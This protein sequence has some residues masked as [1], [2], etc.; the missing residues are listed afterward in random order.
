MGLVRKK[1]RINTYSLYGK[2]KKQVS[3]HR[4]L[5]QVN[6]YLK[7][8]SNAKSTT[9]QNQ[10]QQVR[11]ERRFEVDD[12]SSASSSDSEA[13]KKQPHPRTLLK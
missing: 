1:S 13:E 3:K 12:D 2:G 11:E 4:E 7:K 9:N 5:K 10:L 6:Y 8:N